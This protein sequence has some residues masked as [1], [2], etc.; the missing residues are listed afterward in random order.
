MV[1]R[2]AGAIEEDPTF[3]SKVPELEEIGG[4]VYIRRDGVTRA[5]MPMAAFVQYITAGRRL[6]RDF[7]ARQGATVQ[8][9][10]FDRDRQAKH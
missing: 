2:I 9:V 5:V 7:H 6:I 1:G 3:V 10:E 4:D 8:H